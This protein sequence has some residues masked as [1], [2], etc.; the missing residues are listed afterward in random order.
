M[1]ARHQR[2][3]CCHDGESA[4]MDHAPCREMPD[5]GRRCVPERAV[6]HRGGGGRGARLVVSRHLVTAHRARVG[7]REPREQAVIV[8]DVPTWKLRHLVPAA[9]HQA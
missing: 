4:C 2:A 5:A 3:A 6:L 7:L 8:Q 9:R 1:S